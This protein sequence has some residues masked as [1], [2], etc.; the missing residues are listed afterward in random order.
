MITLE[1]KSYEVTFGTSTQ[2]PYLNGTLKPMGAL[3]T[4]YYGAGHVSLDNYIA[5]ISGQPV[6]L[7]TQRDCPTFSDFKQT[8]T[9]GDGIAIGN[10]CVYPGSVK[11]LPNQLKAR[12]LTWKG[13]MEDM[14]ND[15]T[16]ES[17]TCGHPVLDTRDATQRAQAP[18]AVVPSGDQYAARHNPFVYFHSIIDAPDCATNVV[19]LD[20]LEA[21]LASVTTTPQFRFH[22]PQPV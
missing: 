9:T 1:N 17:A 3:L 12:G 2:A 20:K 11:T 19:T 15:P 7:D 6:S 21:D 22:H 10:G 13:Y 5:M 16:R 18:S 14:G 8:G 4:N